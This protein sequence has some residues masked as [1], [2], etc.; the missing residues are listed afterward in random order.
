M[1]PTEEQAARFRGE[2]FSPAH[3]KHARYMQAWIR[4][5]QPPMPHELGP[6]PEVLRG[7]R[8]CEGCGI[9]VV[10]PHF[11]GEVVTQCSACPPRRV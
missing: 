3:L 11:Q 2:M 10:E 5:G 4:L 7:A 8:P 1:T 6:T 9:D